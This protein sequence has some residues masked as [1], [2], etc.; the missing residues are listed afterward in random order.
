MIKTEIKI[1]TVPEDCL[2]GLA[3][4]SNTRRQSS[5]EQRSA[6]PREAATPT[7]AQ[8]AFK[9]EPTGQPRTSAEDPTDL[10]VLEKES[11]LPEKPV[12][13]EKPVGVETVSDDV[14]DDREMPELTIEKAERGE[15][16]KTT[17]NS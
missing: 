17:T 14:S 9:P 10:P 5:C 15:G 2:A 6:S 1:G 13:E 3:Q 16:K 12:K 7:S 4:V 11:S 8:V